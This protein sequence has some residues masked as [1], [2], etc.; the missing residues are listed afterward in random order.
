MMVQGVP[1][2][3]FHFDFVIIS[4]TENFNVQAKLTNF[5]SLC[6]ENDFRVNLFQSSLEFAIFRFYFYFY[7]LCEKWIKLTNK[8][9]NWENNSNGKLRA[10]IRDHPSVTVPPTLPLHLHP[11]ATVPAPTTTAPPSTATPS[12]QPPPPRDGLGLGPATA[13][14]L[15]EEG[16]PISNCL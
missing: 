14:Y 6:V 7:S 15:A 16:C 9:L 11:P 3:C 1:Q 12:L 5:Y 10:P 8:N 4:E 13:K 2:Y